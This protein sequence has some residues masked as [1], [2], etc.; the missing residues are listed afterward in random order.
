MQSQNLFGINACLAKAGLTGLSGAATTF[1]T[2]NALVYAIGGKA[3]A[4]A[5]VAGGASP[6]VDGVTGLPITLVANKGTV[7]V[8]AL[9]A[10]GTVFAVQ[11]STE[12]LLP[13]GNF[14]LAAPQFPSMP[15]T[16]TPFA[17][18]ITKAGATARRHLDVRRVEL[19]RHRHESRC[20][21]RHR[22]AGAPA[23]R[24]SD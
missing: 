5:A 4:K 11:G 24:V 13:S 17:Y 8:W 16:L 2:A 20:A 3:Y 14:M 7:I 12:A 18:S 22:A 9:D 21:G 15:D 23:N 19:E 6:V 1:T 10:A